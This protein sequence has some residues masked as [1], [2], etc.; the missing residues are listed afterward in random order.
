MTSHRLPSLRQLGAAAV[1]A[2]LAAS[3]AWA[4]P[5]VRTIEKDIETSSSD[6]SIPASAPATVLLSTCGS[7]CP[8]SLAL[9]VNTETY[10]G[11][12]AVTLVQ[13]HDYTTNHRVGMTL[14]YDP[15]SKVLNRVIADES[16]N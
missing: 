10:I 4:V 15:V 8:N 16:R 14:F 5:F 13:L 9:T 7:A 2:L 1:L 3:S 6:V 12:K 11:T